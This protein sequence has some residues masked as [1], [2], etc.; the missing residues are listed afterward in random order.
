M[1]PDAIDTTAEDLTLTKFERSEL[2]R[3]EDVIRDGLDSFIKVG[4]ALATIRDKRLYRESH[5][6]FAAYCEDRWML[7]RAYADRLVGAAEVVANLTPMG[8]IQPT[9]ERQIRPLTRLAPE[10]QPVA[11][12]KAVE[13]A[14]DGKVTARHVESVVREMAQPAIVHDDHEPEPESAVELVTLIPQAP[15]SVLHSSASNEWYTPARY[16]EAVR[17]VMGGIDLDPASNP[18]A[19]E[20]IKAATFYTQ[21]TDGFNREWRGRVFLNPPYGHEDGESNQARWSAKLIEEYQSG[22]VTEAILLVNATTDRE[23]FKPLWDYLLCFTDHRI[24]FYTPEGEGNSPTHGNVF[25]YFGPHIDRF[26]TVFGRFGAIA[27]R[28]A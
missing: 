5:P 12:A 18:L 4:E 9:N 25:V 26:C 1:L 6:T 20:T 8:V 14:P 16:L 2:V 10:Q 13:T 24:R 19:N 11:W 17:E 7:S 23:W 22:R 15:R 3:C 27:Q 28:I 21:E